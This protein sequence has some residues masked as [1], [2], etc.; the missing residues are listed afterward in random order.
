M[1]LSVPGRTP[2]TTARCLLVLSALAYLP[3]LRAQEFIEGPS[4]IALYGP[5][6]FPSGRHAFQDVY[7]V[8]LPQHERIR[9]ISEGLLGNGGISYFRAVYPEDLVS[10]Y[11]V[12]STLPAD[13]D[14][15]SDFDAQLHREQQNATVVNTASGSERYRVQVR[16]G[17]PQPV[18]EVAITNIGEARDNTPFPIARPIYAEADTPPHTRSVHRIF[19]RGRNRFEVALLGQPAA[20][21]AAGFATLERRL[22]ELADQITESVQRCR[23]LPSDYSSSAIDPVTRALPIDLYPETSAP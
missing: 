9:S 12:T 4:T 10:A 15:R 1:R 13:L 22:D 23:L 14:E 20:P 18:L 11:V 5:T 2:L 6:A 8:E 7:C 17:H 16:A 3:A 21:D 19:V